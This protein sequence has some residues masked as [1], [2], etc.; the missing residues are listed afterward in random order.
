MVEITFNNKMDVPIASGGELFVDE[1][2]ITFLLKQAN[3]RFRKNQSL[4]K[5]FEKD[6]KKKL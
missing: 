5:R 4:L 2:F 6:I 3:E 1:K